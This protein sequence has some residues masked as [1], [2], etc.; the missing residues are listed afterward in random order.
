MQNL[1]IAKERGVTLVALIITI[2]V[3]IIMAAVSINTVLKSNFIDTATQSTI[4]YADAQSDEQKKMEDLSTKLDDTI[5]KI[6]DY[7]YY[8]KPTII[9]SNETDIGKYVD[10]VPAS[11]S[12]GKDFLDAYSGRTENNQFITDTSLKWRIWKVDSKS[13][14]LISDKQISTGGY[15]N[16]GR[17]FLSTS[18]GYNNG[19]TLLDNICKACYSNSSYSGLKSQNMKIEDIIE[20]VTVENNSKNIYNTAPYTYTDHYFPT[21]WCNNEKDAGNAI[22]NRSIAYALTNETS[23]QGT[24]SP[25]YT[26]W[27]NRSMNVDTAYSNPKYKEL[28]TDVASSNGHWL[29]SRY[30]SFSGDWDSEYGLQY[31]DAFGVNTYYI[32]SSSGRFWKARCMGR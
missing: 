10:Y 23:T 22:N 7:N 29:S 30:A 19:V 5:N 4:N 3:L 28:V 6:T 2:I 25:F 9:P 15:T 13:I 14:Y 17:L 32:H 18:L 8:P 12:Y 20:A 11:G 16:N 1:K 27:I 24:Y 21:L 31:L 26:A